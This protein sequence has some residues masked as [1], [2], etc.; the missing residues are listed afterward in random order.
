MD[1]LFED[2]PSETMQ[3]VYEGHYALPGDNAKPNLLRIVV[4]YGDGAVFVVRSESRQPQPAL[5][6]VQRFYEPQDDDWRAGHGVAFDQACQ[7]L[8]QTQ[9]ELVTT[10]YQELV[11]SPGWAA[12]PPCVFENYLIAER[13]RHPLPV[14][15]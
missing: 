7:L 12:P 14:M 10:G 15:H 13:S 6:D 9:S 3:V 1:E 11:S 4:D 2:A 5:T 8:Q